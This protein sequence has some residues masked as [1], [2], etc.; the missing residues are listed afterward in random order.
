MKALIAVAN[1]AALT[2]V[3]VGCPSQNSNTNGN[4]NNST[5]SA[6][7]PAAWQRSSGTLF[8]SSKSE[9]AYLVFNADHTFELHHRDPGVGYINCSGGLFQQGGALVTLNFPGPESWVVLL[10]YE[11]PDADTLN[12]TDVDGEVTVLT[13]VTLPAAAECVELNVLNTYTGLPRPSNWSGLAYGGSLLWYTNGDGLVQRVGLSGAVGPAGHL[14]FNLVQGYQADALWLLSSAAPDR[15]RSECRNG[16]D[17][18]QDQVDTAVLG[19]PTSL[20][21]LAY[22][23][24]NHVLWML[25]SAAGGEG[26][27]MLRVNSDA[28]PNVLLDVRPFDALSRSVAWHGASLWLLL[29]EDDSV[30]QVEPTTLAPLRTYTPPS[31]VEWVALAWVG[32]FLYL[33]GTDSG[34]DGVLIQTQP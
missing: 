10:A 12:L 19:A 24:V 28:D 34:G 29:G 32:D 3:L 25:G 18:L 11:L 4:D 15:Q 16:F 33:L 30:V 31:D 9:L 8:T 6:L 17:E 2:F 1:I 21:C 20:D 22:D 14:S 7:Y 27:Q 13:R 23:E 26:R 5:A